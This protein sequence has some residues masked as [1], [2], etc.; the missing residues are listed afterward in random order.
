MSLVAYNIDLKCQII[1]FCCILSQFAP[2][3]CSTRSFII[4]LTVLKSLT[5]SIKQLMTIIL[6]SLQHGI[7]VETFSNVENYHNM[8]C[9]TKYN[10]YNL[11]Q[12]SGI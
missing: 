4:K 6:Q 9:Y 7:E 5:S 2:I 1:A 12:T 3:V 10:N 8:T 11:M